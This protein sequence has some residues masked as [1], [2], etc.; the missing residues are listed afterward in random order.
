MEK[1]FRSAPKV[2]LELLRGQ[3]EEGAVPDSCFLQPPGER[4]AEHGVAGRDSAACRRLGHVRV[5]WH[6]FAATRDDD[7]P[8]ALP[9]LRLFVAAGPPDSGVN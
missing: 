1:R 3:A 2:Y 7:R 8:H 9:V 5:A 6:P 4:L